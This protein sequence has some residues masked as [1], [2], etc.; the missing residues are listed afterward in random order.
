MSEQGK[1][2]IDD[3]WLALWKKQDLQRPPVRPEW[4]AD[5]LRRSE[6]TLKRSLRFY[7]GFALL[8]SIGAAA[9]LLSFGA[10][11]LLWVVFIGASTIA[12]Y[13]WSVYRRVR[14]IEDFNHSVVEHLERLAD[15]YGRQLSRWF[16]AAACV[17]WLAVMTLQVRIDGVDG[18]YT[19][20]NHLEFALISAAMFVITWLGMRL[21][22][23][24]AL[25]EL[26]AAAADLR[27]G[28]LDRTPE[29]ILLT[30]H[31]QRWRLVLLCVLV[32]G[33]VAGLFLWWK[34]SE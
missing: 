10:I 2:P 20:H 33:V 34:A 22:M 7:S 29:A 14:L 13:S 16:L 5:S 21:S 8:T 31:A 32:M 30:K 1:P 28:S 11:P 3:A 15:L 27:Q 18:H 9:N 17:P 24:S 25:R 6:H 23:R 26:R 12:V 4:L 19:I